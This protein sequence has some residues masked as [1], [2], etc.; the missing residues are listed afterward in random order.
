MVSLAAGPASALNSQSLDSSL[1]T[2][3][4]TSFEIDGSLCCSM[5]IQTVLSTGARSE[6]HAENVEPDLGEL[7]VGTL[8]CR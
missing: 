4:R 2:C 6:G 3:T 1:A 8:L 5:D 7:P